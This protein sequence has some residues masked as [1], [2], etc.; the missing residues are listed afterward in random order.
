VSG[1]G[2][3]TA[4][5]ITEFGGFLVA[6][7]FDRFIELPLQASEGVHGDFVADFAGEFFQ[8][9]DFVGFGEGLVLAEAAEEIA[10]VFD[11]LFD[12]A[13]GGFVVFVAV[14]DGGLGAAIHHDDVGT[15]LLEDEA[16][17]LVIGEF[18]AEIQN[19]QVAGGIAHDGD[20]IFEDEEAEVALVIHDG[21][22]AEGLALVGGEVE[23]EIG[24]VADAVFVEFGFVIIE[25]RF[26]AVGTS[27]VWAA[28]HIHLEDAEIDAH[29]KFWGSVEAGD[30]AD[31]DGSG[32][33]IP[34]F[35]D[36]GNISAGHAPFIA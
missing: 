11:A 20:E 31:V 34:A 1:G 2:L 25:E 19:L 26:A 13:E 12:D 32:F 5:L 18:A 23:A 33:V 27:A 24:S 17:V 30:F 9:A 6:F 28:G 22:F 7:G 14:M 29:L 16:V 3:H 21:F 8:D 4:D 15:I 10:D 35:E 36:G